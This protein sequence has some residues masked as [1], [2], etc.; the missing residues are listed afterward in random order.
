MA[1]YTKR[2]DKGETGLYQEDASKDERVSKDS[3]KI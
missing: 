1:I 2:G 3:L